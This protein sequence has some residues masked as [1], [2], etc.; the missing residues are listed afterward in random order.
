MAWCVAASAQGYGNAYFFGDSDVDSG[1]YLGTLKNGTPVWGKYTKPGGTHWTAHVG[2]ALGVGVSPFFSANAAG[3]S[4]AYGNNPTG[5]NAAI[6]GARTDLLPGD[7]VST[8]LPASSQ[9]S[10]LIKANAGAL[11]SSALYFYR[12]GFNDINLVDSNFNLQATS[13]SVTLAGDAV[14]P[15]LQTLKNAGARYVIYANSG[16]PEAINAGDLTDTFNQA[17][18]RSIVRSGLAVLQADLNGLTR[19]VAENPALYGF[20]DESSDCA[21]EA[22]A[23]ALQP[24]LAQ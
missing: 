2:A 1:S 22:A 21:A 13:A 18:N 17:V 16:Q 24:S 11:N 20:L 3:F 23:L 12:A 19:H 10:H 4:P 7:L 9:V 6:G 14:V 8:A 5:N 15:A